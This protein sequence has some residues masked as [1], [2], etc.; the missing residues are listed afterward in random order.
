MTWPPRTSLTEVLDGVNAPGGRRF[1]SCGTDLGFS[2]TSYVRPRWDVLMSAL[3]NAPLGKTV[4]AWELLPYQ[5]GRAFRSAPSGC[6]R[7]RATIA[8]RSTCAEE[9]RSRSRSSSSAT[10]IDPLLLP[11]H[12][13]IT[14]GGR[15]RR[16]AHLRRGLSRPHAG[17]RP[18]DPAQAL[19]VHDRPQPLPLDASRPA[20]AVELDRDLP[21]AG[22][23]EQ[24][25]R[26]DCAS[27]SRTS[28]TCRT[29]SAPLCSWPR[30]A[31]CR[32]RTSARS[33]TARRPA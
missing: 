17:R 29:S 18:R 7:L 10:A 1:G 11:P 6:S 4:L 12:A 3:I 15:G 5:S 9:T 33:S 13:R 30:S 2:P 26:H 22:L 28:A 31:T 27:S 14:G 20:R 23:A 8:W 21:T 24:V 16:P 19:A 32:T 25:E